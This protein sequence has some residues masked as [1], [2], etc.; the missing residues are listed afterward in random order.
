MER[1]WIIAVFM[2]V[3]LTACGGTAATSTSQSGSSPA[4]G[5]TGAEAAMEAPAAEQS[6]RDVAA[7]GGSTA[8]ESSAATANEKQAAPFGRMVIRNATLSLLI[9]NADEAERAARAIVE[10]LGGYVLESSTSGDVEQR[11]ARLVFKVP[12]EQFDTAINNLEA[13]AIKVQNRSITGQDVTEEFV[14]TQS[15]LRNLE[16]TETRLLEFLEQAKT[17]EEALM[18]NQ[19]LTELQGQIEQARGRI[20]FLQQSVAFSTIT[21]DLQPEVIFALAPRAGWRPGVVAR[22][23]WENLLQ[24]AQ[25]LANVAIAFA[26][27]SPVWGLM[28]LAGLLVW[29]RW[30]RPAP[31]PHQSPQP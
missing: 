3:V 26:I 25:G 28:L 19:Q 14:D 13:L 11:S 21:L 8:G 10:R 27:W 24:F 23:S 2:L 15:R 6:E 16:A 31:P 17:V 29:R 1:R 12:V 7:A 30:G 5:S 4:A 18:V 9:K 22:E 20:E